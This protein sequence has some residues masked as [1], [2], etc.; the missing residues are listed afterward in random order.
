MF[1]QEIHQ[2]IPAQGVTPWILSEDGYCEATI[3]CCVDFDLQITDIRSLH[4]THPRIIV[5]IQFVHTEWCFLIKLHHR[6]K[7]E[8]A[9]RRRPVVA[10]QSGACALHSALPRQAEGLAQR[11]STLDFG[12][13]TYQTRGSSRGD[14]WGIMAP[15]KWVWSLTHVSSNAISTTI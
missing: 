12:S 5:P 4:K 1:L 11:L 6:L 2:V 3:A 14:S 7:D 13:L 8:S 9:S 15:Q 10:F